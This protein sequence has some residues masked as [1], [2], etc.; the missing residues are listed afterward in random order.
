MILERGDTLPLDTNEKFLSDGEAAA[1]SLMS[2]RESKIP[3]LPTTEKH[4]LLLASCWPWFWQSPLH[5]L[6]VL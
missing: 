1:S 6:T 3:G 4:K 2:S 5:R